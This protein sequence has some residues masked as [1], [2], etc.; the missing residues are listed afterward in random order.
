MSYFTV[1]HIP[2]ANYKIPMMI[3]YSQNETFY[4]SERNLHPKTVAFIHSFNGHILNF[5]QT[6]RFFKYKEDYQKECIEDILKNKDIYIPMG[7]INM[8]IITLMNT[9]DKSWQIDKQEKELCHLKE[10]ILHIKTELSEKQLKLECLL[11]D[12]AKI[13]AM[14]SKHYEESN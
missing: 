7:E 2:D 9:D 6:K 4:V 13:E 14:I 5:N 12:A 8:G 3:E 10:E 1:V 11:Q